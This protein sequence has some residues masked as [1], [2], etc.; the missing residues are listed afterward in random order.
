MAL[1]RLP[2]PDELDGLQVQAAL[3]EI[4]LGEVTL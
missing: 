1:G 3:Q 2:T 4:D